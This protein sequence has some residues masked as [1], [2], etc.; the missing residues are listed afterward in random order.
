MLISVAMTHTLSKII[1]LYS[2]HV[3]SRLLS[4]AFGVHGDP[5]TGLWLLNT[6]VNDTLIQFTQMAD[7]LA[8]RDTASSS[9]T[10]T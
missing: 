5:M 10:K 7:D 4:K 1:L 6:I 8:S 2:R 3:V 9:L